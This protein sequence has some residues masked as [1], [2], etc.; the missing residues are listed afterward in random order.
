LNANF[1]KL[2]LEL[3]LELNTLGYIHWR[4]WVMDV[5]LPQRTL[6]TFIELKSKLFSKLLIIQKRVIY[7][8]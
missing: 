8:T 3:N 2:T 5:D 4:F 1:N 6:H 7:I